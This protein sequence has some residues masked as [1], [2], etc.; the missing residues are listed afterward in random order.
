MSMNATLV[1]E[2]TSLMEKHW[3]FL[4]SKWPEMKPTKFHRTMIKSVSEINHIKE[5]VLKKLGPIPVFFFLVVLFPIENHHYPGPYRNVEKGLLILYHLLEGSTF[6]EMGRFIPQSTFHNIYKSFYYRSVNNGL[7]EQVTGLMAKM[8]SNIKIRILSAKEYNPSSFKTVTLYL[9]GHD[10]RGKEIGSRSRDGYSYKLKKAGF[11]TQVCID[12]NRLVLFVSDSLPC[13]DNSDGVMFTQMNLRNKMNRG[14]CMALDGGY[15][16]FVNKVA[17]DPLS[18]A[19][20]CYPIRKQKNAELS[21]QVKKF[22]EEFGSFRS[23]IEHFFGE[24][25]RIFE[26]FNNKRPIITSN[27]VGFSLQFKV[28]CLLYNIKRFVEIGRIPTQP[29]HILWM[30]NLFDY[31][32]GDSL[33]FESLRISTLKE[34]AE[35]SEKMSKYQAQLLANTDMG[36]SDEEMEETYEVDR[37][38]NHDDEG[39][40]M[41]YLVKWKGFRKRTWE[42]ESAFNTT[43][44]IEDYWRRLGRYSELQ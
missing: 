20:F 42:L 35:H 10:T 37:V 43:Q 33:D 44:C 14:D 9:D 34:T 19:N 31:P 2:F 7:D 1:K 32:S 17:N 11:R 4:Y 8:S 38:L 22:N 15:T 23:S 28:A 30:E 13:K 39:E 21:A 40:E 29:S 25:G 41:K 36:G 18:K 5:I 26:K 24:L 6:D 27:A 16:L 3:M 12:V